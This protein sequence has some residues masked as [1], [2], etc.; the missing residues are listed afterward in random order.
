MWDKIDYNSPWVRDICK[1]F[2]SIGGFL[3]MG[4]WML[5]IT[6]FPDRPPFRAYIKRVMHAIL[7]CLFIWSF[8]GY[9][10]NFVQ[11][12]QQC[13]PAVTSCLTSVVCFVQSC[14]Y[15]VSN[16]YKLGYCKKYLKAQY[17]CNRS[18]IEKQHFSNKTA[19]IN[20]QNISLHTC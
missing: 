3:G 12:C 16:S 15:V 9:K 1:I 17:L 6:F 10:K 20:V 7:V 11:Y 13:K 2:A 14:H 5:P 19:N 4:H 8:R 18:P